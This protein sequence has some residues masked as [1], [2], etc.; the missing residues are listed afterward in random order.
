MTKRIFFYVQHLLGIGHLARASHVAQAMVR[1]GMQV[2]MVT[3]GSPVEGF[4]GPGVTHVSLPEI[5]ASDAEFTALTDA[6]GVEIDDAFMTRRRDLLIAAYHAA[7]PDVVM[8]EAYP[9]GR[10]QVRFE[11]VP[12]LKEIHRQTP[13]PKVV[14]S[15]RDILQERSK[16]GRAAETLAVARRYF[17]HILVHGDPTFIRLGET[18][19]LAAELADMT[20][21]GGIVAAPLPPPAQDRFDIVVSAGGGAVGASLLSAV[22]G[23]IPLLPGTL[24]WCVIG[25]VNQP[26]PAFAAL[27]ASL[28]GNATLTRFR[29]DFGGLLRNATLSVSQAGYNTVCNALQAECRILLVPFAGGGETEQ[30]LRATRLRSLGLANVLFQTDLTAKTLAAAVLQTLAAPPPPPNTLDLDGADHAARLIANL[31]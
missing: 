28:P 17:D 26:E 13:R 9:F 16:P 15:V 18:Y 3:G 1:H 10:R 2:T 6:A 5:R 25:G 29:T 14:S 22:A 21:Y 8:I 11:L 30:T 23:A 27:Q 12:L 4:P 19:A 24:S 7:Q 20:L 31:A